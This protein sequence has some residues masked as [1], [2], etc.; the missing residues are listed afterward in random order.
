MKLIFILHL[1]MKAR[2]FIVLLFLLLY[3]KCELDHN[4]ISKYKCGVDLDSSLSSFMTVTPIKGLKSPNYE[5]RLNND[6][7]KKFNIYLDTLNLEDEM[8]KYNLTHYRTL[9]LDAMSNAIKHWNHY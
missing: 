6:D 2:I 5:R 7:F 4:I 8:V 1:K 3:A 9:F